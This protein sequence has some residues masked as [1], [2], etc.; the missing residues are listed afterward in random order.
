[1]QFSLSLSLYLSTGRW[2]TIVAAS[3]SPS[4]RCTVW[5]RT[6]YPSANR[7]Q[8]LPARGLVSWLPST[9]SST[10]RSEI[11][12]RVMWRSCEVTWSLSQVFLAVDGLVCSSSV[13]HTPCH[14]PLQQRRS[15]VH[16]GGGCRRQCLLCQYLSSLYSGTSLRR[17]TWIH[18]FCPL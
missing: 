14:T 18:I 13:D 1:M 15:V 16:W 17:T 11:F 5:V 3:L 8:P 4:P 6:W 9:P 7:S 12:S 2:R 10:S